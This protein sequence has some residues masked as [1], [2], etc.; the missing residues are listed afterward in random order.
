MA[1]DEEGRL[2]LY[3]CEKNTKAGMFNLRRIVWVTD[4]PFYP[5]QATRQLWPVPRTKT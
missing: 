1:V 4:L 2:G 3:F 5:L